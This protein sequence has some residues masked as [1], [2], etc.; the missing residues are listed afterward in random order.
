MQHYFFGNGTNHHYDGL[1]VEETD[2]QRIDIP[3]GGSDS[4]SARPTPAVRFTAA[5]E[6]QVLHL[7]ILFCS[8]TYHE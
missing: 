2:R 6:K 8:D 7:K 4:S 3:S 5:T 1:A